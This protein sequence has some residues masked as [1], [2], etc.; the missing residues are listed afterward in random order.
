MSEVYIVP[1]DLNPDKIDP[2]TGKLEEPIMMFDQLIVGHS[3]DEG[4]KSKTPGKNEEE[5]EP[6]EETEIYEYK[7]IQ[8]QLGWLKQYYPTMDKFEGI[9]LPVISGREVITCDNSRFSRVTRL[10]A[11]RSG[12]VF[13]VPYYGMDGALKGAI[14]AII[15][16]HALRDLMPRNDFALINHNNGYMALSHDAG[17]ERK[18]GNWVAQ[19]KPDPGLLFSAAIPIALNDP[20]SQWSL[21]VGF[22]DERFLTS[23][24][25]MAI[26]SFEYAGYGSSVAFVLLCLVL[27]ALMQRNFVLIKSK[28]NELEDK[29]QERTKELKLAL[30]KA[31]GATKAKSEFLANM[32]HEIRTPMNGII[33]MANLL[34]DTELRRTQINYTRTIMQ[35]ADNLLQIINDIL[36]FSKIE[37][38]KIDLEIIPFD[39]QLLCEEVCELMG[40]KAAEK[41][42]KMQL[43]FSSTMPRYVLGDP[44][45]V[46]QIL[47]NLV[48]NAIKFTESGHVYIAIE[49]TKVA[50]GKLEYKISVEDTGIGI[51]EEKISRLFNVFTQADSSTTRKYGGT[52]LGL[53]ISKEL[54]Q[55]MGGAIGLNST[56]GVGSTFWFKVVLA[57]DDV[58]G[59]ES[60]FP[61][62]MSLKDARVLH[63]DDDETARTI[64]KDLLIPS[65][66]EVVSVSSGNEALNLLTHDKHFDAVITDYIMP[67]M[68]GEQLG[69]RILND[70][71]TK[72]LPLLIVTSAPKKGDRKRLEETGFAG[73]LG[74]PLDPE[75]FR[76]SVA[77]LVT[78]K[79]NGQTIPFITQHTIK[80]SEAY[81]RQS[82]V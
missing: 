15:L 14:S 59:A 29:V 26:R 75:M 44:G 72:H 11:D 1:A 58:G 12:L 62:T 80:E 28:N 63:V 22:P 17:Q 76:K 49:A 61:K 4:N 66:V 24:D 43:K 50:V 35:S 77:L 54:A 2:V 74:M 16:S 70:E 5:L 40:V 31:Q 57:E 13:S 52:G 65:G 10:D 38:G 69:N 33:G 73:Y 37:A 34:L 45:R 68:N 47:L 8:E 46:R 9:N 56:K 30:H 7:L 32:S 82:I 39:I 60:A 25:Y 18:S 20:Q 55:K 41:K 48:N 71:A 36:D 51:A 67:E 53:A 19:N 79:K 64:I 78:A 21:W 3:L 42:L 27:C 81:K 23:G 6:L